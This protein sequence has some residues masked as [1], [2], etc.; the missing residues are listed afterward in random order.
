MLIWFICQAIMALS[1]RVRPL[2]LRQD[3]RPRPG[4]E[5]HNTGNVP[6]A[7]LPTPSTQM[8]ENKGPA[9]PTTFQLFLQPSPQPS[10]SSAESRPTALRLTKGHAQNTPNVGPIW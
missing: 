3:W 6:L 5:R 1:L 7:P 10:A 8:A 2:C 9:W 4:S